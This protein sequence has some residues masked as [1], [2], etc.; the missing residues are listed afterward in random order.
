M[1]PAEICSKLWP[2]EMTALQAMIVIS[3]AEQRRLS[4]AAHAALQSFLLRNLPVEGVVKSRA[5][6]VL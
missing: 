5:A 1:L 2:C 4:T 3:R 6:L